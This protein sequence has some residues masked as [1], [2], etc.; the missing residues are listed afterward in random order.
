MRNLFIILFITLV[1]TT[2]KA[3]DIPSIVLEEEYLTV[4]EAVIDTTAFAPVRV[5]QS[6]PARLS[7][8]ALPYSMTTNQPDWKRLWI[9]AGIFATAYISTLTVLEDLPEGATNWN[10]AAIQSI[11]WYKRWDK[12][13]LKQGPEWDG[14][15]VVF[16]YI[17]HPYAGA[18][19]FMSARSAGFNFYRSLLFSAIVSTVG[20]EFGIEGTMERP[21]IQDIF[22]TPIV[23]SVLGEL[24]YHAKRYI[25]DNDYRLLGSRV[26]GCAAC[27]VLDPVNEIVGLFCGDHAK[28]TN[29]RRGVTSALTP[30][31]TPKGFALTLSCTF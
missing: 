30:A 22:I 21:S 29:Q 4:E 24:F 10:K 31:V 5:R 7:L 14:D 8:Y 2:A 18:V 28:I 20:W 1:G 15:A 25:V 11:P 3:A 19:Y 9:N 16:N 26:L 23:G 13:V 12:H 27:F 6:K 17:L